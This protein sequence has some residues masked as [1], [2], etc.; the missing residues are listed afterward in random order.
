[1]DIGRIITSDACVEEGMTF[2]GRLDSRFAD[3]RAQTG[4][5]PLRLRPGGFAAL[6]KA[7]V[8]QQ[9]SVA[10]ATAIWGKMESA[11]LNGGSAIQRASDDDLRGVGLSRQKM[12]Y[13]RALAA[14]DL[15][16]A[17]LE[18]KPNDVVIKELTEISGIGNWTAE[19]YAMFSLGRADVFAHGDLALQEGA[20]VLFDLPERPREKD[21]RALAAAWSPWRGVAARALWAYYAHIKKREGVT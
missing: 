16:F 7:I 18:H 10:S 4:P 15:D 1:M 2:L 14:A 12:K 19:V 11:G 6:A 9:V 8:G 13:L 17:A 5:L 20:R 21:M 3:L